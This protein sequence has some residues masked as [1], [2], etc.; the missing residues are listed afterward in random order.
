MPHSESLF[1]SLVVFREVDFPLLYFT[2]LLSIL[3]LNIVLE[4]L[5]S[6]VAQPHSTGNG[7]WIARRIKY[8][9]NKNKNKNKNDLQRRIDPPHL[10]LHL[11]MHVNWRYQIKGASLIHITWSSVDLTSPNSSLLNF[12]FFHNDGI[13]LELAEEI[14]L[15]N[16]YCLF[17]YVLD[18]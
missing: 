4:F 11:K 5:K 7:E 8:F 12:T 18:S 13:L 14:D 3:G 16:F 6:S 15:Y 10:I 9:L 2:L 1:I 17:E